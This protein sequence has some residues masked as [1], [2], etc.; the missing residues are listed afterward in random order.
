M[1]HRGLRNAGVITICVGVLTIVLIVLRQTQ[2]LG[3]FSRSLRRVTSTPVEFEVA[4]IVILCGAGVVVLGIVMVVAAAML[5][6][7]AQAGAGPDVETEQGEQQDQPVG[8]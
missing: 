6:A 2:L 7:R 8:D 5:R 3:L 4:G 1:S